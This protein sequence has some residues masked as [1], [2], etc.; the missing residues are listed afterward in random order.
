MGGNELPA[1]FIPGV[2]SQMDCE[3][4]KIK[5]LCI[6]NFAIHKVALEI[7]NRDSD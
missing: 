1:C 6:A 4:C 7:L 5:N 2:T 3:K